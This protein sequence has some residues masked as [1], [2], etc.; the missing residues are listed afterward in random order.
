MSELSQLIAAKLRDDTFWVSGLRHPT[1][2]LR[3]F[4]A[5]GG[6]LKTYDGNTIILFHD[7]WSKREGV[8]LFNKERID[9]GDITDEEI[10]KIIDDLLYSGEFAEDRGTPQERRGV[11]H[12]K[13]NAERNARLKAEREAE[14]LASAN[15]EGNA[16][17]TAGYEEL[18]PELT[19]I[20]A[21]VFASI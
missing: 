5:N 14:L 7:S 20:S 9:K 8:Y 19:A 15:A 17:A 10:C 11:V 18:D 1:D 16:N 3:R 21:D 12:R 6:G 4:L 2:A 13:R